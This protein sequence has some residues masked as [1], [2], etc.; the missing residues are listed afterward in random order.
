RAWR[1]SPVASALAALAYAFG[2]PVL[3]QYSNVIFLVGAA[4]APWGLAAVELL[5]ARR[6]RSGLLGLALVLAMQVLGG[7]PEAASLTALCGGVYAIVLASREGPWLSPVSR[8]LR[9]PW[10]GALLVVLWV[11]AVVLADLGCPRGADLPWNAIRRGIQ[12]LLWGGL[13]MG[14]AWSWR[15]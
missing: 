10:V 11:G 7:D 9:R 4:W 6:R 8:A 2:A 15:R 13:G 5:L 14:V 3:F 1:R 12:A